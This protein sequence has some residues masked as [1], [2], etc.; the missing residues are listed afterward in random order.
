MQTKRR[1]IG[2]RAFYAM[3]LSVAVP[4]MVQH[5]ITSFVNLL[6]NVMVGRVGT[7]EMSGVAIAN[8]LIMIFELGI[9]GGLSGAGIF[10]AQ[11][12]GS[13]NL[14]GVR[15]AFRIKLF[16]GLFVCLA[17]IAVFL[18]FGR[19]LDSCSTDDENEAGLAD[20][21]GFNMLGG[22][23][24]LCHY[25]NRDPE[26]TERSRRYLLKLSETKPVY[27]IPEE[28][29]ILAEDGR[30]GFIGNR[31]YYEFRGGTVT[32]RKPDRTSAAGRQ[33]AGSPGQNRH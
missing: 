11:Y 14:E 25:T 18:I 1:L 13:G 33:Q 22:W 20:H 30:I 32:E 21:T 31:P 12:F 27:A 10:A 5:G 28:D 19:D 2:D 6:D 23:S 26:R 24:L 7:E 8:Q 15:N 3:V 16:I 17:A 4:I 29:T 9:F